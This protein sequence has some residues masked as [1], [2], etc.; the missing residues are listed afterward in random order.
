MQIYFHD[1]LIKALV[2]LNFLDVRFEIHMDQTEQIGQEE[3]MSLHLHSDKPRRSTK[4]ASFAV[5][6]EW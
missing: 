5:A 1:Q 4:A 2:D 3:R 6:S